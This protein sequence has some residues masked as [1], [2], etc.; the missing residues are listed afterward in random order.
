GKFGSPSFQGFFFSKPEIVSGRE[1]PSHKL[2]HLR[3]I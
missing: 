3:L 1:V 2:A